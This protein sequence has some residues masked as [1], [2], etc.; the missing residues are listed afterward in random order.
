M[1]ISKL[2]IN[3]I[4]FFF[5]FFE[6][7]SQEI[8]FKASEM[9][10]KNDGN[11][12]FAYFSETVIPEKN[13]TINSNK[14]KYNKKTNIL[15]FKDKVILTDKDNNVIVNGEEIIYMKDK[16]IFHSI[17]D[18]KFFIDSKYK[19]FSEDIYF[20]RKLKTIYGNEY[21]KIIDEEKNIFNLKNEFRFNITNEILK[22]KNSEIID[23][24]KNIYEFDDLVANLKINEIA[25][26]EIN[27]EFNKSYFGNEDNDPVLKGRSSY[28]NEQELKVYK[29]VFSTCNV[30]EKQCRGWELNTDEFTH[31]KKKRIFEYKNSWLKIFDYKLLFVPYFN[32][33]DP[34]VNRKSGFLNPTYSSSDSLGT[35]IIFPY[36]KILDIDKDVTFSPRYYADK[37]FLMQN[38]YRQALQNSNILSDFSFL[39]G[40]AGTKG[41]LFYKQS[42]KIDNIANFDLN[43][44]NVKGDNYLKTHKLMEGSSL[45]TS[46]SLLLSNLDL[47]WNLKDANLSTSFKI[48][49]DLSR[50]YHDR[51]QFVFPD[52]DF[53]KNILIPN[54]Y[55]GK[56]N[57]NSYGF[58][59]LYDTNITET[60][61]TNDF[62]FNSNNFINQKGIST[63]FDMMLKNSN[64]Y[65]NN[66]T[67]Y[68]NN[69]NY[70][71]FGILKVD[72]SYPLKKISESSINYLK[73]IISLRYS[74]N[75]NTDLSDKDVQL[76]YNS[77]FDLNRIGSTSQVEGGESLSLGLEF[78][79]NNLINSNSIDLNIANILKFDEDYK[80][81]SKSKLNN[82]RSDIFGNLNYNFNKDFNFHYIFSYDKDLKYSNLDQVGIDLSVNNFLTN[83]SY[84]SE[85]NDL[86][87]AE[88]IIN[89]SKY[90]LNSENKLGFEL[91]KDLNNNFTQYYKLIYTHET[92]CISL[93]LN[94]NKSFFRDGSL[95]PSKSLSFLIKIIPF[96]ELGVPSVNSLVGN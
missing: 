21:T 92:D 6:A 42:G 47:D 28:T 74:P 80:M 1:K 72:T 9:D 60:V 56:F 38:E 8:E 69:L 81:P 5:I 64:N 63:N 10:V 82:K 4:I 41:H 79:K 66:S 36:F 89:K 76:N 14:V 29:A 31:D 3:L 75:G 20:D 68:N 90:L 26:K 53:S 67:N 25:G 37:S 35:S 40:N 23:N 86:E 52:F 30:K 16:D 13:I 84:H 2:F 18:T 96:T 17:G 73:P 15:V 51:Y 83:I 57:F 24:N 11:I 50:N 87:N 70:N 45:I 91:S 46:D 93:N 58:N 95:E 39:V 59:K 33:P 34:S 32:H 19:V 61:L 27:V 49:E 62:F 85:H 55:N 78:K 48:Y 54:S 88:S 77:V 12:I 43:L 44:Q 7:I 94:Y 65:S 71:L 22:S